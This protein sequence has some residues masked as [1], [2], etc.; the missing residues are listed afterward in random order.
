MRLDGRFTVLNISFVVVEGLGKKLDPDLD[1]TAQAR[2]FLEA[3]VLGA[4]GG[5]AAAAEPRLKV[6]PAS[7]L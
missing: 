6:A 3:A 1:I 4:L 7:S 5:S 2:P